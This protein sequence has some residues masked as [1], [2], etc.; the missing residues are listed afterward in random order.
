[1]AP[2]GLHFSSFCH[3]LGHQ[4]PCFCCFQGPI[5]TIFLTPPLPPILLGL[6]TLKLSPTLPNHSPPS[7]PPCQL[8]AAFLTSSLLTS[9][10]PLLLTRLASFLTIPG[11][12]RLRCALLCQYL[13]IYQPFAF[14]HT[15]FAKAVWVGLATCLLES[16]AVFPE[17]PPLPVHRTSEDVMVLLCLHSHLQW[18]FHQR[19]IPQLFC[20]GRPLCLL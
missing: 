5:L 2:R 11:T 9:H 20:S 17:Q 12:C 15:R 13:G 19:A 1:M 10:F 4:H 8:Y 18:P 16:L 7:L 14:H 6:Q 3:P